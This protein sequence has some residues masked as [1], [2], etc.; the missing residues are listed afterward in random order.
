MRIAINHIPFVQVII[1]PNR[2]L[3]HNTYFNLCR[4]KQAMQTLSIAGQYIMPHE[5]ST[6]MSPHIEKHSCSQTRNQL[7][8][9]RKHIRS[10]LI[11]S[12]FISHASKKGQLQEE[13][14][15]ATRPISAL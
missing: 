3:I 13:S 7:C 5:L 6:E 15:R 4:R 2:C 12:L 11:L 8:I 10:N 14:E 9:W 1:Y